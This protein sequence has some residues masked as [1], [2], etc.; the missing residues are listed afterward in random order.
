MM[1]LYDFY[2]LTQDTLKILQYIIIIHTVQ[3]QKSQPL[4]YEH[5][6]ISPSTPPL[7]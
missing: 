1:I 2:S 3:I 5:D 4:A 6:Y 7:G